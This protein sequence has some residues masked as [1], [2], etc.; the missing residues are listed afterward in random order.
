MVRTVY[1]LLVGIDNYPSP[2]PG[3]NGCVNDVE[4]MRSWLDVRAGGAGHALSV[5]VLTNAEATRDRVIREFREH[6][7][8]AGADDIALF[9]FSGHGSQEPSPVEF[10][11]LEPDHL[12][13]TLVCYDSRLPDGWDLADK[14][15]A[16]LISEVAAGNPHLVVILDSCHSGSGTRAFDDR[17]TVRRAPRFPRTRPIDTFIVTPERATA[18][19]QEISS[20]SAGQ[21]RPSGWFVL[22]KGRHVVLSACRSNEEAKEVLLGGE[23]RGIF[24]YYLLDTL[25]RA[26]RPVTYRELFK[27][28]GALVQAN[29]ANQAPQIEPTDLVDLDGL[30]LDGA[31]APRSPHFTLRHDPTLGWTIDGGLVHGVPRP[32]GEETAIFA[33]FPFDAGDEQMA[34]VGTAVGTARVDE[35]LPARSRVT[36][37]SDSA[38]LDP[39]TIYKAVLIATPIPPLTV[40]MEGDA[41]AL[42]RVRAALARLGG[43]QGRS[44]LVREAEAAESA[45]TPATPGGPASIDLRLEARDGRYRIVRPADTH[46]LAVDIV[47]FDDAGA[48]KAAQRL[49]HIA[50]WTRVLGL[51]SP[52]SG[53]PENAVMM[54]VYRVPAGSGEQPAPDQLVEVVPGVDDL[55]LEYALVGGAWQSPRFKIWLKNTTTRPLYVMLLTVTETYGVWPGLLPGGGIWLDPNEETWAYRDQPIPAFIPDDLWEQGLVEIRDVLKLVVS[56]EE[57]D[58]TLLDQ[59]DLDATFQAKGITRAALPMNTLQRMLRRVQTRHFGRQNNGD[60]LVDWRTSDLTFV[61]VRPQHLV[62]VPQPGESTALGFGVVVQGH[63]SL[64]A[65]LRLAGT[66]EAARDL[67]NLALPALL[68][69]D[70]SV[71]TPFEFVAGRGGASGLSAIEIDYAEQDGET[72]VTP[73]A[74]LVLSV[75]VTL[76]PGEHVLAVGW[77]GDVFLP[78]GRGVRRADGVDLVLDQLPSPTS[79]GRKDLKGSARIFFQKIAGSYLGYDYRYPLLAAT[80]L[81]DDV[82]AYTTDLDAVARRVAQANR[83]LVCVHGIIGD[84]RGMA[85]C[86]HRLNTGTPSG[87]RLAQPYDLILT[88]DYEN[89]GTNLEDTAYDFKQRLLHVGLKEGHGKTVHLMTHSMGGLVSR[90]LIE[91]QGGSA[92]IERLVMLGTPNGGSPWPTVQG[93]AT[94]A[95]G[96]GLNAMSTVAWPVRVLGGLLVAFEKVDVT[97]DAMEPSSLFLRNLGSSP[98]PGISY[99]I[100]AGNT[101]IRPEAL[102]QT[103]ERGPLRRP[104]DRLSPR[105]VLHAATALAFFLAPNDIAVSVASITAVPTRRTPSPTVVEI[106]CDHVTYFDSEAGMRAIV[107]ALA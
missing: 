45:G 10:W 77:D 50:R 96:I 9:Y 70:P 99:R 57:C 78:V 105:R 86:A 92:M 14:E 60:A 46:P 35:V 48:Q 103:E 94:A 69:E 75:P 64:R 76:R 80:D 26:G 93:W 104:F 66:P 81:H 73:D 29:V 15:L 4:R 83:I 87:L 11:H 37:G 95:L 74:P 56:T 32:V 88:F 71:S 1:A 28:T 33:L 82:V 34:S 47:G 101:S 65:T 89:L 6:L 107:D 97:L 58:A 16:Q 52:A 23:P 22:P 31:I 55:R 100:I 7:G 62:E 41:H 106:A 25:Q 2:V 27:R 102:G 44:L 63:P 17:V 39:A 3:L 19:A 53:L 51:D 8:E 84:T 85:A 90:W 12:D 49:E 72:M 38:D 13:E 67:G 36:L 91:H 79:A 30:F 18:H 54:K 61:T 98:D 68:R 24:S 40:A 21:G 59:G 5:R 43:A 20:P 42:D